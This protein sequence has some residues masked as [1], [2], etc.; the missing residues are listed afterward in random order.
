MKFGAVVCRGTE[1]FWGDPVKLVFCILSLISAST[2][3]ISE[4]N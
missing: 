2:N 3:Q 1:K 4:D